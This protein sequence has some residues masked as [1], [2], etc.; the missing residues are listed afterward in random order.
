MVAKQRFRRRGDI[1]K[2]DLAFFAN[3]VLWDVCDVAGR[4]LGK[5]GKSHAFRLGLDDAAEP[6]IHEQTVID[7]PRGGL[8]LSNSDAEAAPRFMST[9]D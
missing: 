3:E 2:S 8:E 7:W 9:F 6:S 5:S 4:L 1:F